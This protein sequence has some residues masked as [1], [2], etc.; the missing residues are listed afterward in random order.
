[1][2]LLAGIAR[3]LFVPLAEAVV[4]AMLASY[5]L[6]RTLVPTLANTGCRSTQHRAK[7][8]HERVFQ[9]FQQGFEQR[10]ERVRERYH[11]LLETA[12]HSGTRFAV[13]LP[14]AM[15]AAAVLAFPLGPLSAG[16]R[17]GLLPDR[18]C[19]PDQAAS[20]RPHRH[21]ASRRPPRCATRSRPG[22]ARSSRPRRSRSIVDNIGLPYSGINLPTALRRRSGPAMPTSSSR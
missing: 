11:T 1:M 15:V 21:C 4:F 19:R 6:S 2:F 7:R 3:F 18:G 16:P 17:P 9:R 14:G 13:H 22:S 8:D 10:F 20:A 12:L 5:L